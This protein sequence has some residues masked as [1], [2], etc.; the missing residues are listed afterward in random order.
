MTVSCH[1]TAEVWVQSSGSADNIGAGRLRVGGGRV[2]RPGIQRRRARDAQR[3]LLRQA[4]LRQHGHEAGWQGFGQRG[5]A[6]RQR[7]SDRA[8]RSSRKCCA[9]KSAPSRPP[10][11]AEL[12]QLL[13]EQL[14]DFCIWNC[15][16]YLMDLPAVASAISSHTRRFRKRNDFEKT[17]GASA[18]PRATRFD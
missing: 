2:Q 13:V 14:E 16:E 4:F 9:S 3:R 8:L 15:I 10:S 18:L 7:R 1:E 17:A 11:N 5:G 12:L 6:G